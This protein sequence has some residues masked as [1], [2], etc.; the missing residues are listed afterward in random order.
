MMIEDAGGNAC[1]KELL[2]GK[3]SMSS[4]YKENTASHIWS[5]TLNPAK[6]SNIRALSVLWNLVYVRW[7]G[8]LCRLLA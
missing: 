7:K 8:T 2:S 4:M 5:Q 6:K 1:A 3:H